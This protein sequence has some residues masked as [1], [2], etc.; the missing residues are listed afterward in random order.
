MEK[1]FICS[2]CETGHPVS[3]LYVMEEEQLC[4]DCCDELTAVCEHCGERIWNSDND[5]FEDAPLCR[6]C[7]DNYYTRCD[8]CDCLLPNREA[9]YTNDEDTPYCGHCY[10]N[11]R[12][13]AIQEYSY[14]PEP[15]FYGDGA[16]Y[17][18]V[19]LEIDNGGKDDQKAQE[20]L[21]IGN[22]QSNYIYIKSDSSLDDGMEI[23]THPMTLA[24]HQSDMPWQQILAHALELG[25]SS[26]KAITCGLHIHV[27]RNCFGTPIGT[28]EDCIS[29]VLFFVER[30]WE[31]LLRFSRRTAHQVKRWAARYGY[32][33]NP[34]AILAHAKEGYFGRYACVNITNYA[35]IEFRIFRGTL[36][37]NTLIA[38]LQLVNEICE[39]AFLLSDEQLAAL[40]WC[41]FVEQLDVHK[42]SE[43]IAYL[44]ERRLYINEPVESE[45]DE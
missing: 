29:R 14:K 19:E 44:K 21:D 2:H 36:K 26:H 27:N 24:F 35:T 28:Q 23:V 45:E 30:F 16:R 38:T 20:L 6:R 9:H 10:E 4:P 41:E 33:N 13:D 37:Y 1:T 25:Y 17:F 34:K 12:G 39:V 8:D 15:I 11:H 7:C 5:G 32:K 43:L 42:Y 18:G 31:E 40:S 22:W 3:S